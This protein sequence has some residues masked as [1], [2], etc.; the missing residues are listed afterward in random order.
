MEDF[1]EDFRIAGWERQ[2]MTNYSIAIGCSIP[3]RM[4]VTHESAK[5]KPHIDS[6][7]STSEES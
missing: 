3:E 7:H 4:A 5:A 1:H 6:T 2:D